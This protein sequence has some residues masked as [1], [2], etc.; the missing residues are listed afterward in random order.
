[1]DVMIDGGVDGGAAGDNEEYLGSQE[2]DRAVRKALEQLQESEK[3]LIERR[4]LLGESYERIGEELN[5]PT[6]ELERQ[7]REATIKLRR[8]LTP[9]VQRRFKVKINSPRR[10]PICERP[11]REEAER[12]IASKHQEETWK[13]IMHELRN[14]LGLEIVS[15]QTLIGHVKYHAKGETKQP[16]IQKGLEQ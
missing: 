11:E 7:L 3:E 16:E 13:R 4:F 2:L 15:P 10:C 8:L 6:R 14:R 9:F 1:M 12:I 5:C